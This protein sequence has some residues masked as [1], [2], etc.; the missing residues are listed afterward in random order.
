MGL[1]DHVRRSVAKSVYLGEDELTA[2][3]AYIVAAHAASMFTRAP[4]LMI[5]STKGSK[6]KTQARKVAEYLVPRPWSV[7]GNSAKYGEARSDMQTH[8]G[9][10]E[11]PTVV[12]DEASKV[13]GESG[14]IG[15]G[16]PLY[17][18]LTSGYEADST[19]PVKSSTGG[20]GETVPVSIYCFMII[21]GLG[22]C[23]PED[24]ATRTIRIEM[25]ERPKHVM[26]IPAETRKEEL[27]MLVAPISGWVARREDRIRDTMSRLASIR[28]ELTDR[29]GEVWGPL[30]AVASADSPDELERLSKAFSAMGLSKPSETRTMDERLF[31]LA[32]ELMGDL[33]GCS[34]MV[35][36]NAVREWPE[37]GGKT[38][39]ELMIMLAGI[40][41]KTKVIRGIGPD[42]KAATGW[43]RELI[44][45]N[46]SLFDQ[47]EPAVIAADEYD[48][49]LEPYVSDESDESD[50]R[51]MEVFH[52]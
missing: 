52:P 51:D 29:T 27:K 39:R 25:T 47:P 12:F 22:T 36:H 3:A 30:F 11:P 7:L 38:P 4:R 18:L 43:H 13:F 40:V 2:Y 20:G 28:P 48:A 44:E 31:E 1:L 5:S 45:F 46:L 50:E 10:A 16:H 8:F 17:T 14:K 37:F 9:N 6:G 33:D 35:L 21:A 19:M 34:S 49:M 23:L 26:L 32:F 15:H 24:A 41:G 42:G